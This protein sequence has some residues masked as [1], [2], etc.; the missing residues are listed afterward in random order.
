MIKVLIKKFIKDYEQVTDKDVRESYSVLGGILGIICN[1]ALFITKLTI[2]VLMNSIAIISDAFNNL[3][4]MFSSIIVIVGSKISNKHADKEH[5]FGHGRAEYVASLIVSFVIIIIGFELFKTSFDKII[6]PERVEFSLL[7][8]GILSTSLLVKLW[9]FSYNKYIS[10]VI[11]SSII[12]VAA[13]DS[14]NDVITTAMIIISTVIGRY[15]SLPVDGMMG[16]IVSGFII[17]SGI[18]ISK[19]ITDLILGAPPN[20]E[21]VKSITSMVLKGDGII[22]VHD[23][24]VHEYGPGRIIASL[25]AEVPDDINIIKIH[26][27]IDDIEQRVNKELDIHLVIHMD[28]I[29][30]NCEKTE[31]VKGC[32]IETVKEINEGFT[33]HDFRMTDGENNIN[34]IFDLVVPIGMKSSERNETVELIKKNLTEI[35]KRYNAVIQVDNAY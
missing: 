32:V 8:I 22:G 28:P 10:A 17:Y 5:P 25:H 31:E 35:D 29:S 20:R 18:K 33:I 14:L 6:N 24:I 9:M 27:V 2:G 21:I 15:T 11:N 1:V 4:D 30:I 16:L 12:N 26:E 13:Y 3:S 23:L 34:L 19:K 7:L